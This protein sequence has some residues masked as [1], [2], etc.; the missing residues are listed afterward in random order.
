[1]N[2]AKF[3]FVDPNLSGSPFIGH[4][5]CQQDRYFVQIGIPIPPSN[6]EYSF[7]PDVDGQAAYKTV[8]EGEMS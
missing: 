7:H 3:H 5:W 2:S 1:M 4:D 8:V 6:T